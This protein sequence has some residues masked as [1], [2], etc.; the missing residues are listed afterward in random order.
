MKILIALARKLRHH[1]GRETVGVS[2]EALRVLR[3][4][5]RAGEA[6][7]VRILA[8]AV[9]GGIRG[10]TPQENSMVLQTEANP[11]G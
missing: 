3:G 9:S 2:H 8:S 1:C 6:Q 7:H 11:S 10:F 4:E 5:S